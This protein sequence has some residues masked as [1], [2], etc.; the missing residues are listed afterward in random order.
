MA[1]QPFQL[2]FYRLAAHIS[3]SFYI[4]VCT[5]I[6]ENVSVVCRGISSVQYTVESTGALPKMTHN[7]YNLNLRN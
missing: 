4:L 5:K 6:I 2:P 3:T 7:S 1:L